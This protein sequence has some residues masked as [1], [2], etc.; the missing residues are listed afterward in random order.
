VPSSPSPVFPIIFE[1]VTEYPTKMKKVSQCFYTLSAT[2]SESEGS[3]I[4]LESYDENGK[5]CTICCVSQSD[6]IFMN[7]GHAGICYKCACETWKSFK[8]CYIC[9]AKIEKILQ[10]QPNDEDFVEIIYAVEINSK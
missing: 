8:K 10:F 4:P 9:R 7:C 1:K 5:F 3:E 2:D 6:S